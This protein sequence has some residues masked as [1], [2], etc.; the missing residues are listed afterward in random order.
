MSDKQ[1]EMIRTLTALFLALGLAACSRI[2]IAPPAKGGWQALEGRPD[3]RIWNPNRAS[4]GKANW[5]G[6]CVKERAEG[7]G[8]LV[9][10][11]PAGGRQLEQVYVGALHRGLRH[12]HGI[13]SWPDGDRYEGYYVNDWAH[14][15]GIYTWGAESRWAGD[16]YDGLWQRGQ[17]H[18]PGLYTKADQAPFRGLWREGV[19][20]A[21][22]PDTPP[23]LTA[24]RAA[25]EIAERPP[26][27]WQ[28]ITNQ[29]NC[30]VW[31]PIAR[32]GDEAA[33]SGACIDGKAHGRGV[34]KWSNGDLLEGILVAGRRQGWAA[35]T[36]ASGTRK[37]GRMENG[38]FIGHGAFWSLVG[39]RHEGTWQDGVL[40]GRG[41]KQWPDG[42]RYDGDFRNGK[43][44]GQGVMIFGSGSKFTGNRYEGGWQ[45]DQP[46]GHGIYTWANGERYD[47]QWANDLRHGQGVTTYLNGNRCEGVW[48]DF[49]LLGEGLFWHAARQ[50]WGSCFWNGKMVKARFDPEPE[51]EREPEGK[52]DERS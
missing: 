39:V 9:W 13:Y 11:Y 25:A 51:S 33:W 40:V 44:H 8:T 32:F 16:R 4:Q 27:Q 12:G 46:H 2:V 50:R 3:C 43:R 31:N 5:D 29:R 52:S 24:A 14:G 37:E 22:G 1:S 41:T 35:V 17:R 45:N 34:L 28:Q 38:I 42:N 21:S 48:R 10:R 49:K 47:G 20:I 15:R 23:S 19:M 26:G 6:P 18:G 36:L 7:E 30:E